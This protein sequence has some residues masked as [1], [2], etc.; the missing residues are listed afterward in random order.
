M[1]YTIIIPESRKTLHWRRKKYLDR[2]YTENRQAR[3]SYCP[4]K[5][6]P[7]NSIF[8]VSINMISYIFSN[9]LNHST[10]FSLTTKYTMTQ[11][12]LLQRPFF[13]Q[14]LTILRIWLG[15]AFIAH[16]L[17]GIFN[18]DYMAGHTGMMELYDIPLPAITAY[19]SKGGELLSGIL[20]F[21]GLFTRLGA[22]IVIINM[23]VATFFAMRSNIFGDFQAEISFTYLLIALAIFL[24]GST[25][26]SLDSMM[27][28]KKEVA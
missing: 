27:G 2:E 10:R 26:F 21:L 4:N 14:P 15:I 25:A 3:M 6:L 22:V 24:K 1:P 16:G 18:P 19:L 17:P 20:L 8:P 7:F 23:F 5:R 28:M 13:K 9:L 12:N 11:S